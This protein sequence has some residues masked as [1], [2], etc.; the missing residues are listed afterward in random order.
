MLNLVIIFL[1]SI[2]FVLYFFFF[3]F[4]P[5][6]F[7]LLRILFPCY[8]GFAFNGHVFDCHKSERLAQVDFDLSLKYFFSNICC[9][10]IFFF[11]FLI[12]GS[13]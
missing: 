10:S 11:A 1:I 12:M 5:S 2:Y 7:F 4:H 3:Q 9:A 13:F 8:F 6:I